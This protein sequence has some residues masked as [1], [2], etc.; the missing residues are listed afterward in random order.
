MYILIYF[1][2]FIDLKKPG[3]LTY[4]QI[5]SLIVGAETWKLFS[6]LYT[7]LSLFGVSLRKPRFRNRSKVLINNFIKQFLFEKG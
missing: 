6:F 5:K 7:N 4:L 3:V 1:P 2:L